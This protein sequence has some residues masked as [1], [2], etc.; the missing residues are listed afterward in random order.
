MGHTWS[1]DHSFPMPD[2]DS[3]LISTGKNSTEPRC[4]C[5][6]WRHLSGAVLTRLTVPA[7][8]SVHVWALDFIFTPA[9]YKSL[10]AS[11]PAGMASIFFGWNRENRVCLSLFAV[12][13]SGDGS[14]HRHSEPLASSTGLTM[15]Q[16]QNCKACLGL[17]VVASGRTVNK[18]DSRLDSA[19]W[20]TGVR[21]W[22]IQCVKVLGVEI[23][24]KSK[25]HHT[26][27]FGTTNMCNLLMSRLKFRFE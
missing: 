22:I 1:P 24:K 17:L 10:S 25:I 19:I 3:V 7:I 27:R 14:P 18:I 21:L 20:G 4:C 2:L 16:L 13:L 5:S 23:R 8:G 12:M 9:L 15:T 26:K 11:T 6:A